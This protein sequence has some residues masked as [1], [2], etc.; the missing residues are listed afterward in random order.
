MTKGA[1]TSD[2]RQKPMPKGAATSDITKSCKDKGE[3]SG[4]G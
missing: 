3:P 1:A 4:E 2:N